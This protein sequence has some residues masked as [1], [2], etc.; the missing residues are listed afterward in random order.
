MKTTLLVSFLLISLISFGQT[1]A[2]PDKTICINNETNLEGTGLPND[3]FFWTSVP[4]DNS[5]SNPNIL[6]PTVSPIVTTE[7]T[8][9]G[10]NVSPLNLVINGDFENG[11]TG[12]TSSYLHSP[13]SNGLWNEGTYAITNDSHFNHNNFFCNQDHTSG[14]TNFM[15]VN[16]AGQANVVVWSTEIDIDA[17]TEY[18]FSTWVA[19]LSP[20]SPA[21]L[22]FSIN[23]ILLG[24]PFHAS[25]IPCEWNKF[26]ELWNSGTNTS[27]IISIVNQNT[28]TNGNDFAFDDINF[29][30]VTYSYDQCIVTVDPLPTSTF[31]ISSQTCTADTTTITYTG[32]GLPTDNYIWDFDNANII[33]GAGAGPYLLNWNTKGIH[34]V[35]LRVE[36]DCI[37]ETTIKDINVHNSPNSVVTADQ[38]EIPFGTSTFLHGQM[39]GN[40][41]PVIFEWLPLDKLQ[42]PQSQ[43]PQTVLLEE[44][45]NYIFTVTD[46]SNQCKASD[47]ITIKVTGS[48]L[49]ILSLTATPQL[50]CMGEST[51][52]NIAI[53]GGSGNYELTWTSDPPGYTHTG[54]ET[55][56]NVSPTENTSYSV[57]VN[58]GF[59]SLPPES[60]QITVL[61]QIEISSQNGDTIVE[62]GQNATFFVEAI[63]QHSF[64]WQVSTDNGTNWTDI[65]DNNIYSGTQNPQLFLNNVNLGMNNYLYRC[66]LEG[67]CN[68]KF[69]QDAKLI[70]MITP[71]FIGELQNVSVCET[72]IFNFQCKIQNFIE[73]DS[74]GLI[75]SY[76]SSILEFVK[77]EDIRPELSSINLTYNED[78]IILSWQSNQGISIADASLFEF[79]FKAKQGGITS[80]EWLSD[81][82]VKNSFGFHPTLNFT[83]NNI[84]IT[85]LPIS[86]T[87]AF[88][89]P[90]SLNILDE[91]DINLEVNGGFGNEL[92]WTKNSCDGDYLG[93]GNP[94]TLFRPD[95]T[96]TYFAKWQNHCGT[97][98]CVNAEVRITEQFLFVVPNAFSPNGDGKNDEFGIISLGTLPFFELTIFN[99]WGQMI[100]K[101]NNQNEKWDGSFNGEKVAI[102]TYIWKA[103]YQ[104]RDKGYESNLH[105]E[106]G[107]VTVIY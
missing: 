41:G 25:A 82:K 96:T 107:S 95:E 54:N 106:S 11:N 68:T 39:I 105:K 26:F 62:E 66:R 5:I 60:I 29:S 99:K 15:A 91:I 1:N 86:P 47:R 24:Q 74:F 17:N 78:Q 27:A 71:D 104:F 83:T 50:V 80:V 34:H 37:S 75:F 12:F 70:V 55:Q 93:D 7:Y 85:A 21:T 10:R 69:S 19:S 31:D 73:I 35:Q 13:G 77:L 58:D 32:T 64:Q 63:N 72:D 46:Q 81:C 33:S 94:L 103:D 65:S 84:E 2:G 4:I 20:I 42:N 76:D 43:D 30:F 45:T 48:P 28:N 16:G 36:G 57:I 40:P 53:E 49:N 100:F 3:T 88:A 23:G 92:I 9:E 56:I 14:S 90:D 8:L 67:D 79:V 87:L 61:P 44:N 102:G 22:Q 98:E 89:T 59:N 97:S 6:T 101:T 51:N 52:I 38:T 18:E